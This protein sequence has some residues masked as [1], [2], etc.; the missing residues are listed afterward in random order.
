[1]DRIIR[2]S[3]LGTALALACAGAATAQDKGTAKKLYCWDQNGQRICSDTLPPDAVNHAREEF[4]AKSGMRSATVDRALTPQE[5]A[6]QAA[7]QAQ[8][9]L[10][11]AAEQTRKRTEQAML[12]SYA[13]EDDLR[14]VFNERTAILDNNVQTA[15]YNV[16]SLRDGLVT[17]LQKAGD[18]ELAG[19]KVPDKLAADIAARHQELLDQQRLLAGFQAQRAALDVEIEQ[20]LQRYRELKGTTAVATAP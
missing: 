14:R 3:L 20:T 16:N 17:Q 11:T 12:T 8:Q 4:N 2:S 1:M 6:A 7:A 15:L 19:H 5:R 18:Q 13:S 10:D 9:Q